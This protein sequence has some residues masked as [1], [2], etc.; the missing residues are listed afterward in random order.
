MRAIAYTRVSTTM[1]VEAGHSLAAQAEAIRKYCELYDLELTDLV[2]DEGASAKTLDRPGLQSVLERLD[3]GEANM[4]VVYKLDRLT[5]SV[6]DLGTLLD[7]YFKEG[8]FELAS[9]VEK[10]DTT[11]SGGRLTLN[12]LTSVA[13][14]EREVISERISSAMQHMKR[15]G[16]RTG[17]IPFGMKLSEDGVH[18][19]DDQEEEVL[20]LIY[21]KRDE[22][23]SLRQ[24]ARWLNAQ[25][26]TN[27]GR[28]WSTM[29]VRSKL[30]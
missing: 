28:P 25:G 27:R 29:T 14:W 30:C 13:Q 24:L 21:M 19:I 20:E 12:I 15:E 9:V 22:K 17:Y 18:L 8:G 4:L 7:G 23:M 6:A 2:S 26:M 11:T 3:A 1:Q 10:I 16:K 5:R